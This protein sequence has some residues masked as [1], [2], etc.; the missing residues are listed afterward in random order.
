MT[1]TLSIPETPEDVEVLAHTV[2]VFMISQIPSSLS[3]D[4]RQILIDLINETNGQY[5]EGSILNQVEVL[6]YE[7]LSEL[8]RASYFA[9]C[10][11]QAYEQT[12]HAALTTVIDGKCT[13]YL[14]D[15]QTAYATIQDIKDGSVVEKHYQDD[16]KS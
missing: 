10:Q 4:L 6:S 8:L 1:G 2:R 15:S 7:E 3:L 5:I 13:Q 12:H 9:F 11:T 16:L 14:F